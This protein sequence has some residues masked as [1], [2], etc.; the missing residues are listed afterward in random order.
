MAINR[1]GMV[2][3]GRRILTRRGADR[4]RGGFNQWWQMPQG[5][6]DPG[7]PPEAAAIRELNEE[8]G[9]RTV[10]VLGCTSDWLTYDLPA[11][12]V[13][14][15]W[16]G[17]YRGQAQLWYALRFLGEDS[18]IDIGPKEGHVQEFDAWRW[19][20]PDEL[21]DLIVP[22]KRDVYSRALA[23]LGGHARSEQQ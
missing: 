13:P 22:F 18:E 14:V 11:A 21:I 1:A 19:A 17:R 2:W 5:G 10:R 8:T 15:N 7:E 23:E 4:R 12:L 9:M 16:G 6:I 3:V 20:A